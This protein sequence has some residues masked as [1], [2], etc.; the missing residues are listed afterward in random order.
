MLSTPVAIRWRIKRRIFQVTPELI[1]A[2]HSS[3][4][5]PVVTIY[6]S[7]ISDS[8]FKLECLQQYFNLGLLL[9]VSDLSIVDGIVEDYHDVDG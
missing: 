3:W 6:T 9:R 1:L 4:S 8:K 2:V 7:S 5:I